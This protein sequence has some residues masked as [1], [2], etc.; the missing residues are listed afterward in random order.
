MQ[1]CFLRTQEDS[2]S[3]RAYSATGAVKSGT[4]TLAQQLAQ[5]LAGNASKPIS[6]AELV[7]RTGID[8]LP[9]VHTQ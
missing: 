9:G 4:A 1:L 5:Q 6:Y 3:R 8:F 7:Q 2:R